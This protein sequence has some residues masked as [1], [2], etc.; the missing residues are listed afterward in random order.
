MVETSSS[1]SSSSYSQLCTRLA[2]LR[3]TLATKLP[4]RVFLPTLT[5]SFVFP[6]DQLGV[7]MSI[8]K[9]HI[10]QMQMEQLSFHQSELTTFFL[11]ALDF[12]AKHC[13]DDLQ[14]ASEVEGSVIECLLTMVMKLSEFTF[15]PLFFKLCDWSKADSAER[16]LTFFRLCDVMASRLKRLF[17][18]FAT[19]LVKPL[20]AILRQTS[21]SGIF[22]FDLKKNCLLLQLG[23]NCLQKIFLYDTKCF[24]NQERAD[25]LLSPLVEQL[26]NQLGGEQ[27]YQQRVTQHLLPCLGQFSVALADDSLWKTLNYEVL[28]KTRHGDSKVRFSSLLMLMELA[29][30]LKENYV[31]LLPETIPFLAELMEGECMCFEASN[32][33]QVQVKGILNSKLQSTFSKIK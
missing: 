15:R 33:T 11:T 31:V 4:S 26:E 2:A 20:A 28:L 17:V 3:S 13:P 6:Q 24:L 10:S 32:R 23:L 30:R 18:L 16:Q 5:K 21:S 29:F 22:F 14:K 25:A 8:M 19:Q 27:V 1:S 7:L 9:E 12:R